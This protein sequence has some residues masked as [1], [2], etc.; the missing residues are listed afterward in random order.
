MKKIIAIASVA[1]MASV[2]S[3]AQG[4][5]SINYTGSSLLV[6]TNGGAGA[7]GKIVGANSYYF[8]LLD[9]TST[10][11]AS[12]ANQIYGNALNAALWTDS[13]VTGAS[14][15]GLSA[16]KVLGSASA[17]AG[18]W[19]AAPSAAAF[20]APDSYIIVGWSANYGSSWANIATAVANG[21][22]GS[23][24]AGWFGDS[25]IGINVAGGNG[26]SAINLWGNQTA[27]P[28]YGLSAGFALTPTPEPAT[29]VLAGLGGLSLLALRRKK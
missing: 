16:G 17:A 4:L 26:A 2:A 10:T 24:G 1:A 3:F 6:S 23:L 12:T 19:A 27:T 25:A 7:T 21:T 8:E 15:A 5:V 20:S 28:G 13:A 9:S 29:M 18:N 22:L 14:G 11:L